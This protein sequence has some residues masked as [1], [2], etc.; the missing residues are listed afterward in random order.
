MDIL[1]SNSCGRP[2]YQ[3][4]YDQ[5]KNAILSG[6][7]REGDMLPSIR[8]LAKDL[9]ISVITTKRAYE[10]LEQGGY[11]YTAAGKGCFV[12]QKSSGMVYEEHLKKIEEHMGEIARLAGSSGITEGQLIEMYR[13]LQEENR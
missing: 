12:S 4:I 10:E 6:E 7:L 1:I 11:I 3:Q 2:I 8:A 9:R 5:V 13:V